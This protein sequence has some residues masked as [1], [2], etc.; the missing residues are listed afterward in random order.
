[1]SAAHAT[2]AR[3]SPVTTDL[4]LIAVF[5]AL[6]AAFALAPAVPVGAFGVPIT[7]QTLAIGLTGMVLGA[8][9]G[10]LATLLY[11]VAGFAGLPVFSGGAAG[12]GVLAT[13]SIGYLLSFPLAAALVGFLSY[14]F[15][16]RWGS[17]WWLLLIAGLAGSIVFVHTGGILGLAA[18]TKVSLARAAAV[19]LAYWPG[20]ILKSLAA[21]LIASQV[22]RALPALAGRR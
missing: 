21:C 16:A 2:A 1:M 19:D 13:P 10:F 20:D 8:R 12:L 14:R 22:H 9:R 3:T 4:A 15:I 11:L 6:I 17:R 7:L 18:I 5:A